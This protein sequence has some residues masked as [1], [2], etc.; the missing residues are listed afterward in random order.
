MDEDPSKQKPISTDAYFDNAIRAV[1]QKKPAPE[2][3][4]TLHTM[5]DNTQVS[6]TDR[7]C[8]GMSTLLQTPTSSPN[9]LHQSAHGLHLRILDS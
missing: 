9:P 4:F 2:I 6:T 1:K 8:K 7:V 5:D 3:D